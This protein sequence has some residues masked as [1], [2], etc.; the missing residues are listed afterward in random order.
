LS[1]PLGFLSASIRPS[2]AQLLVATGR[3]DAALREVDFALERQPYE[4][5]WHTIRASILYCATR[6]VEAIAATDRAFAIDNRFRN[7]WEWRARALFQLGRGDEAIQALAKGVYAD[8][9]AALERAVSEGGAEAGL[10]HLLAITGDWPAR[11]EFAWRR[12]PWRLLL[13]DRE[14]G[15]DELEKAYEL[16]NYHLMYLKVDPVYD[17]IRAHPRFQAI[18]AGVG[19]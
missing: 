11:E 17:P 8:H 7:A 18:L 19:L 15:L 13:G 4:I 12:G 6:Y 3:L 14:G 1:S 16:R 2:Y 5:G 10:R 9:A